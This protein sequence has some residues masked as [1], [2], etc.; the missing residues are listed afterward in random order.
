MS[1]R[2]DDV[3]RRVD[4]EAAPIAL[5][6][7]LWSWSNA[8]ELAEQEKIASVTN[9]AFWGMSTDHPNIPYPF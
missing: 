6:L 8:D 5:R 2:L 4:E 3:A 7:L 9:R 1:T